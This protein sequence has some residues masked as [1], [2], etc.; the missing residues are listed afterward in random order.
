MFVAVAGHSLW[1]CQWFSTGVG[2]HGGRFFFLGGGGGLKNLREIP[3]RHRILEI[4]GV[5]GVD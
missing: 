1:H 3:W 4:S 5:T 2:F